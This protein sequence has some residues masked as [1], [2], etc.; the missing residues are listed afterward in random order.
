MD[1]EAE[2][3]RIGHVLPPMVAAAEGATSTK[4][5]AK[6]CGPNQTRVCI[7]GST[8]VG[9]CG[10]DRL[11]CILCTLLRKL[12]SRKGHIGEGVHP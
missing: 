10:N 3:G 11:L 1:V 4:M 5:E 7:C 9:S 6:F 12:F 2:E 8:W